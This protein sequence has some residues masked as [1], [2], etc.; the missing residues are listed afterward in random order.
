MIGLAGGGALLSK[1]TAG[2]L[3]L[4]VGALDVL[5][6]QL[7]RWLARPWPWR[8]AALPSLCFP[9]GAGL[10]RRAWLGLLCKQGGR[11]TRGDAVRPGDI[12]L[13]RRP[14]GPHHAGSVRAAS[15]GRMDDGPAGWRSCA[16]VGML[17]ALWFLVPAAFFLAV[18]PFVKIQANWLAAAWPAA[19]LALARLV[20]RYGAA[21]GIAPRVF[22]SAGLGGAMVA[23]VWLYAITPFGSVFNRDPLA[24]ADRPTRLCRR[25]RRLRAPQCQQANHQR[26]LRDRE[27]A[28][29]LC[30]FRAA[31]THITEKPRYAGFTPQPV[32]L[33]A[34]VVARRPDV[35]AILIEPFSIS[36]PGVEVWRN[37]GAKPRAVLFCSFA[38]G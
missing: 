23:L 15:A 36:S 33:P 20:D 12:R 35:P 19:F 14:D 38:T 27:P 26:R 31:V 7:R 5:T 17:L 4:A 21:A 10:E 25:D 37:Y 11:L 13:C 29:F 22:W 2:L 8:A 18:S 6:P 30:A 1:Y 3:A 24:V 34:I 16:P 28:A 9:A 32:T